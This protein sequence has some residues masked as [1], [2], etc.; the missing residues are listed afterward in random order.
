MKNEEDYVTP[1]P[2]SKT[3][4]LIAAMSAERES[5]ADGIAEIQRFL[6]CSGVPVRKRL[7]DREE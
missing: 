5:D 4:R 2:Y 1:Q 3:L 7:P 6:E